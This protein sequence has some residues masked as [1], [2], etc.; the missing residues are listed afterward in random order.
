MRIS[1][2][3]V[4]VPDTTPAPEIMYKHAQGVQKGLTATQK[5]KKKK[6]EGVVT[7]FMLFFTVHF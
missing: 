4:R 1:Y 3:W 2:G 5:K 6:K 7:N